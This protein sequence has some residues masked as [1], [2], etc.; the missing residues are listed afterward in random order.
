MVMP[1]NG[2]PLSMVWH[3][4]ILANSSSNRSLL[5]GKKKWGE[6]RS[7][8]LWWQNLSSLVPDATVLRQFVGRWFWDSA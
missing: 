5:D 3:P 6:Y 4:T 1:I 7:G 8:Y 2:M